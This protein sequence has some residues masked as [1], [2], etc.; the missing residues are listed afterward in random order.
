MISQGASEINLTFVIEEDEV[1]EVIQRLHKTFF[2][3]LDS[4]VFA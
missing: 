2:S 1:P 4:E 3:D